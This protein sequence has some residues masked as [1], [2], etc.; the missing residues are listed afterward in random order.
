MNGYINHIEQAKQ[1]LKPGMIVCINADSIDGCIDVRIKEIIG[2]AVFA[3]PVEWDDERVF[4]DDYIEVGTPDR[5]TYTDFIGAVY[6][7]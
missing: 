5:Y 1:I 7:V 6:V 4:D 3:V 2:D